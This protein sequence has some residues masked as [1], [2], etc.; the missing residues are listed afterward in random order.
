MGFKTITIMKDVELPYMPKFRKG[1]QVRV[2]NRKK[3]EL[4]GKSIDELL[5]ER[6]FARYETGK[7]RDEVKKEK[8]SSSSRKEVSVR[9]TKNGQTIS[10]Q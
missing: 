10:E 4:E 9:K 3:E 5:V 1:Q 6:G 7:S 8:Q 2:S